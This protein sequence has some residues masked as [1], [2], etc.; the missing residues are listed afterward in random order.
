IFIAVSSLSMVLG[1]LIGSAFG[2][3]TIEADPLIMNGV[4]TLLLKWLLSMAICS[5]LLLL[6]TG[7]RNKTLAAIVG[8]I[9]GTGTLGLVY[10]GLSSAVTNIF[11]TEGFN[12]AMYMPDGLMGVVNVSANTGVLNTVIVSAVCIALFFALTIRIFNTRDIK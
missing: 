2:T 3:Y 4:L 12:L 9:F 10:M 6:T 11:K 7:V 8:V 5:I 1:N